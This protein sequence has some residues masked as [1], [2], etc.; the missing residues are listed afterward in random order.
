MILSFNSFK[1]ALDD[2][3]Y[4]NGQKIF[5]K[6]YIIEIVD[7]FDNVILGNL[8]DGRSVNIFRD[9]SVHDSQLYLADVCLIHTGEDFQDY[10]EESETKSLDDIIVEFVNNVRKLSKNNVVNFNL[11][12]DANGF[13]VKNTTQFGKRIKNLSGEYVKE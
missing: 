9:R 2:D 1:N 8:N 10:I 3:R 6:D 5:Y 4:D 11:N 7:V 12:I 13:E